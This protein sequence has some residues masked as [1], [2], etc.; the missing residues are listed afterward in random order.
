[1]YMS[2]QLASHLSHQSMNVFPRVVLAASAVAPL[3]AA[4]KWRDAQIEY[5]QHERWLALMEK[6]VRWHQDGKPDP[7]PHHL[8]WYLS[9]LY[10]LN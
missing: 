6:C 3:L 1:M 4:K 5:K 9:D 8:C 2:S 7:E 10:P